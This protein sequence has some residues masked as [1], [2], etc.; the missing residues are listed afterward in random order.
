VI[1]T[2]TDLRKDQTLA[3]IKLFLRYCRVAVPTAMLASCIT[4]LKTQPEGI[5]FHDV[6][7]F[8]SSLATQPEMQQLYRQAPFIYSMLFHHVL[9][10]NLS[11]PI[12][13]ETIL[14]LSSSIS[15]EVK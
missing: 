11:K 1:V 8:L 5:S 14:W 10:V 6:A 13:S 3:N 2:D 7:R 9:Q 4:Y 12:S 15:Q